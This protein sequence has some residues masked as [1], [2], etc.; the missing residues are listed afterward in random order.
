MANLLT[1]TVSN[2]EIVDTSAAG[3]SESKAKETKNGTLGK[4]AFLQLLV[5]Q[6]KYQD[7]LEPMDNTEYISQLATFTQV[8]EIQNMHAALQQ[9]EGNAL[10]GKTVVLKTTNAATGSTTEVMGVV[11]GVTHEG[12]KTY[13]RVNNSTY[14]IDDLTTVLDNA[15]VDALSLAQSFSVAVRSLPAKS[16]LTLADEAKVAN[17]GAAYAAMTDYEKR[18]I[19]EEDLK[20]LTEAAEQIALLRKNAEGEPSGG[21]DD[22]T[23]P[24][25]QI[26]PE[27]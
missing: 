13:L 22:N 7:P 9:M 15:Y 16:M 10:V 1:Q 6:M 24:T 19:A 3:M 18:F 25:D 12:T 27:E 2:G 21:D 11:D 14:S 20:R 26:P 23:P 4:E 5:A 8:E 17:L